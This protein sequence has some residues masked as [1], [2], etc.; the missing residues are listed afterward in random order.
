MVYQSWRQGV[1]VEVAHA[2]R[3]DHHRCLLVVKGIYDFLESLRR[4]IEIVAVQL[5]CK[6]AAVLAIDGY[7]PAATDA[8]IVSHRHN[9]YETSRLLVVSGF[10][11]ASDFIKNL[12]SAVGRMIVDHDDVELEIG[13]LAQRTL[14]GIRD[15]LLSVENWDDHRSLVE[16]FLFAEIRLA[17]KAGIDEGSHLV[18]VLRAS[19]FHLYLHLSVARVHIV[20]LL[21]AALSVVEFIFCIEEFIE[22]ENLSHA[23]QVET[24][25]VETRILIVSSVLLGDEVTEGLRLDEPE[26]SEIEVVAKATRLVINNRMLDQLAGFRFLFSFQFMSFCSI[27]FCFMSF[28][29][30]FFFF[31]SNFCSLIIFFD[32]GIIVGVNHDGTCIV[33]RA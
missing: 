19:L 12:A 18:E 32:Q 10:H 23:A 16:E 5:D 7:I 11:L 31:S 25:V 2:V 13:F 14:H 33:C 6:L 4:R 20:E 17:I 30:I 28:S 21:L 15:G 29:S 3:A 26:A 24:E 22:M 27:R 9:L 1:E 8:E